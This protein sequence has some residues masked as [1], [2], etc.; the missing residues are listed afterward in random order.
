LAERAL[1]LVQSL[2]PP[3]I[4]ARDLEECLRLQLEKKLADA[5]DDTSRI[6]LENALKLA[7]SLEDLARGKYAKVGKSLGMAAD[8][9]KAGFEL[10][11]T[12]NPKP[13]SG[14]ATSREPT[15]YVWPELE[16]IGSAS[17]AQVI[18][19]DE[20]LPT[21]VLSHEC[22]GLLR[23]ANDPGTQRYLAEKKKEALSLISALKRRKRTLLQIAF[24]ILAK[25]PELAAGG[26][27]CIKPMRLKDIAADIGAHESTVSRAANGKYICV[28]GKCVELKSLFT[29]SSGG[30]ES[31]SMG[32]KQSIREL[33]SG[34]NPQKP[35]SDQ[36]ITEILE[37]CGC[38]I[39]RRAVAKYRADMGIASAS[40]RK[41]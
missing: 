33:V 4:A 24:A 32:V 17:G 25:Q 38:A 12:L 8:E 14:F 2:D 11:K 34:E 27:D 28:A 22:A 31:S 37:G 41:R 13:G 16:I 40:L 3:G 30:G 36:K 18:C 39:S 26:I 23:K 20:D 10:I 6:M 29:P 15:G 19:H 5:G 1:A 7:G 9:A 21:L 35:L